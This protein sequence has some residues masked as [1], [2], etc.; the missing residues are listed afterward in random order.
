[1]SKF[2]FAD[3]TFRDISKPFVLDS[4]SLSIFLVITLILIWYFYDIIQKKDY[5]PAKQ[6][7][8]EI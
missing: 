1:M 4:D 6:G 8:F 7:D 5:I 3:L 2:I